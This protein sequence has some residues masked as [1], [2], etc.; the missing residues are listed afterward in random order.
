MQMRSL[1]HKCEQE[2]GGGQRKIT[3]QDR[4]VAFWDYQARISCG[5]TPALHSIT[6]HYLFKRSPEGSAV[7]P[8]RKCYLS[9]NHS[10]EIQDVLKTHCSLCSC[11]LLRFHLYAPEHVSQ[12][13]IHVQFFIHVCPVC[14]KS[15]CR[16]GAPKAL[17]LFVFKISSLILF[18]FHRGK[19]LLSISST[20]IR[21][22]AQAFYPALLSCTSHRQIR[23]PSLNTS[24]II[25]DFSHH[26]IRRSSSEM[27]IIIKTSIIIKNVAYRHKRHSSNASLVIDVAHH[28]KCRFFKMSLIIKNVAHHQKHCSS[29]KMSL[30]I[31][32]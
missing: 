5:L 15:R 14:P 22:F 1:L 30:V 24:V 26:E 8:I 25:K 13:N 17:I 4:H 31:E 11:A 7:L 32:K 3:F 28:Q 12:T 20:P 9:L 19:A 18:T 29:S 10:S 27:S 6:Q 2:L 16:V 23:R 21:S